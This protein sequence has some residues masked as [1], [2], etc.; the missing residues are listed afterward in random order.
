MTR[1]ALDL[2]TL[3]AI[4]VHVHVEIDDEGHT[5]LPQRFLDASAQYF[6]SGHRTPS[7][8]AIADYYRSRNI[9][10]VIFTVDTEPV[11]GHPPISNDAVAD[12]A[13]RHPDILIPF[14]SIAPS[15][16]Q[17]GAEE[18]ER[19][20]VDKGV[21][22]V[23]FHPSLQNFA[24][25]DGSADGLY[26]VLAKYRLPALF[27]TGQN[28]I[29]AGMPG[30]AGVKLRFSNPLYLD[31]VCADFPDMTVIMAH[32][33]VPWQDEAI[34]IATHKPNAY[35]DLSGWSPKYFP[36]QLVKAANAQLKRKVLFATDYPV[37]DTD[38]WI[39]DFETLEIKDEV[40]PLIFKE[41]AIRALRLNEEI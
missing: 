20:I 6:K 19:L 18:L 38:R 5:A 10:A 37:L 40:K 9:A 39:T 27:H 32:P 30:G 25:N 31:D 34:T 28:G 16:G 3:K 12:G 14:A 29:G 15:R 35:I 11:T 8:D 4:D 1:H 23:K 41:N 7:I 21:R 26:A 13:A 33:S 2:E 22:G 17:Q 24:P 36:P